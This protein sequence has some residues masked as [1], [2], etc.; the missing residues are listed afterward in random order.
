MVKDHIKDDVRL[1]EYDPT[2]G[3]VCYRYSLDSMRRFFER[4]E[5]CYALL[6]YFWAKGKEL[7]DETFL[8]RCNTKPDFKY[9]YRLFFEKA[10]ATLEKGGPSSLNARLLKIVQQDL[11]IDESFLN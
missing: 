6:A 1:S 8:N 5:L 7:P 2:I 3:D 4:P 10:F 9:V 11:K